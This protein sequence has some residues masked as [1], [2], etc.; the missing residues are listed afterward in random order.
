MI[1][2][3]SS[4]PGIVY[5]VGAGPGDPGLIT[6]RAMECLR[7]ADL[8]LY[9]YLVNPAV[10]EHASASAE[11][12]CLGHHSTGRSLAPEAIVAG[13]LEAARSG[14]TVVRL[15]GGDPSIFGRGGDE[16]EALRRAG[17]PFEIVP[18]V[19]AGLAA[20]AFCEIPITHHDDASAVAFV[21]GQERHCKK[22]P[23][24]DYGALAA[25]P[26]TLVFYMGVTT[27]AQWSG[28]LIA[29]GKPADTPVAIIRR[30]TWAQQQM[31]RCTLATV[32]ETVERM[33]LRPPAVFVVGRA[34]DRAPHPPWFA[35][36][37][38]FSTCVLVAGSP[39]TCQPIRARLAALGADVIAQPAIRI[40][41]PPDWAPVDAAL[42]QLQQYDGLIFTSGNGVDYF[43]ERLFRS[44]GDLRRLGS[45][46]LAVLGA[47]TAERLGQYHLRA[48]VVCEPL[49]GGSPVQALAA[50]LGG[51]RL[52]LAGANGDRHV[53]AIGLEQNGARVDQI[54]VYDTVDAEGPDPEVAT[55]LR[56]GEIHWVAVTSSATARSLARL[57]GDG[58]RNARLA[59]V[60]STT[61]A[62]LSELG[63][64]P[65]VEASP[66][67][68]AG[69]VE[70]I[71]RIGRDGR[72][73]ALRPGP[74]QAAFPPLSPGTN[75]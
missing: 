54:V 52:L 60:N 2:A 34:V 14:R 24:L 43:F 73:T 11:L 70:A 46:R 47:D 59:S 31:V 64:E 32:A 8:V 27:A 38:L 44:G 55:A 19:T 30:C 25:F 71:L 58:L 28:A 37:P 75:V 7:R 57:Y 61:S 23:S 48:D 45:P 4:S 12:V 51:Q 20:A 39:R 15:K 17:L 65:T 13:M 53:V 3:T 49:P 29:Q 67:T 40:T 68:A 63:Y 22:A 74:A 42:D 5:L 66:Q 18:G 10:L 26:G 1:P 50:E 36:R 56:S 62:A 35:A 69:L 72:G 6:L 41:D 16:T 33:G 9:D 21:A